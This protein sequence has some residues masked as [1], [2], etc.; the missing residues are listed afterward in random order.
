[1]AHPARAWSPHL[2]SIQFPHETRQGVAVAGLLL[3]ASLAEVREVGE[4]TV[5]PSA[6]AG[7]TG[8]YELVFA[9]SAS[10]DVFD[11]RPLT[12]H[13]TSHG[14]FAELGWWRAYLRST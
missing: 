5:A 4:A 12:A 3:F 1:M 13:S 9:P 11:M 10:L 6:G 8:H 7:V 14:Q 2:A